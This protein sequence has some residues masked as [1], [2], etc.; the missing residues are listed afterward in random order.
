MT[1]AGG[2]G[3]IAE[4]VRPQMIIW[5]TRIVCWMSKVTN[6]LGICNTHYFSTRTIVTQERLYVMLYLHRLFHFS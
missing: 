1:C 6:T 4:Q 2:E 5:S 3:E